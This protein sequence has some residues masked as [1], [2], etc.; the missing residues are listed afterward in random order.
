MFQPSR[1]ASISKATACGKPDSSVGD[2]RQ[3]NVSGTSSGRAT[4]LPAST[5]AKIGGR[6]CQSA[7]VDKERRRIW[8]NFKADLRNLAGSI[9]EEPTAW[10]FIA[11]RSGE[12][13][14]D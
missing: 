4:P 6:S 3:S 14:C 9:V 10:D 13:R 5:R 12:Q 1:R 2:G 8:G 11:M 7:R